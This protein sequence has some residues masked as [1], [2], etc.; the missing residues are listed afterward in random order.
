MPD[1]KLRWSLIYAIFAETNMSRI[2]KKAQV[3]ITSTQQVTLKGN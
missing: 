1:I 3:L 2:L